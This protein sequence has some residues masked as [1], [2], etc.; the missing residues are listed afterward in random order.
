MYARTIGIILVLSH[1]LSGCAVTNL[2]TDED[3][4]QEKTAAYFGVKPSDVVISQY[5]KDLLATSYQ[6]RHKGILFNCIIYYGAVNC[7]QPGK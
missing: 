7:K 5:K 6:A 4:A 2:M 3:L 1:L